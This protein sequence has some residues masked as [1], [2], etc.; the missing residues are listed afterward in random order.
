M[1]EHLVL[2]QRP[3]ETRKWPI[4]HSW[5]LSETFPNYGN[6]VEWEKKIANRFQRATKRGKFLPAAWEF[7]IVQPSAENQVF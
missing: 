2:I 1:A 5:L 4:Y 6:A 7:D 3:W